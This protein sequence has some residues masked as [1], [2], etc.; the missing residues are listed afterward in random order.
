MRPRPPTFLL[1]RPAAL[2]IGVIGEF[3]TGPENQMTEVLVGT[4]SGV[5]QSPVVVFGAL[6]SLAR[7]RLFTLI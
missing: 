4:Q 7:L 3:G 2:R 6:K 1:Q 5:N